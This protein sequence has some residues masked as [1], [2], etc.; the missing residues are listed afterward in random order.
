MIRSLVVFVR[1]VIHVRYP[2]VQNDI[3]L[4]GVRQW[5]TAVR[6]IMVLVLTVPVAQVNPIMRFHSINLGVVSSVL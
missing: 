4:T 6:I 1:Y 3:N 2:T 5:V